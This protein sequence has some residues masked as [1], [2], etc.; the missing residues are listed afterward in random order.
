M[1][2]ERLNKV[3]HERVR[4]AVMSALVARGSLT[5]VELK[6]LLELTDGN[7]S[8]H[9]NVLEKHGLIAVRKEFV[10]RKPRTTFTVTARGRQEFQR[11]VDELVHIIKPKS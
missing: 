5:F 1:K 4:L 3:I 6:E 10:R 9:G 2:P 11:Y 8:V 7:L